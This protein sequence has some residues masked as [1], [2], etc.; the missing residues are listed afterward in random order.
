MLTYGQ[1]V[2]Q[3]TASGGP[4]ALEN[5]TTPHG[6]CRA[7][8]SRPQSIQQAIAASGN[9]Y[10]DK[11]FLVQGESRTSCR[12]LAAQTFG[13]SNLLIDRYGMQ[14]GDRLG[15][16]APNGS[17]WLTAFLGA[18]AAGGVVVLLKQQWQT[19]ELDFAMRH[20]L[21]RFLVVDESLWPKVAPALPNLPNIEKV[22]FIGD[23][24]PPAGTVPFRELNSSPTLTPPR[25]TVH[26]DDP[27][28]IIYTSGTTGQPKGVVSTHLGSITQAQGI[29]LD[30][31]ARRLSS[32]D[33]VAEAQAT[34]S[35]C[36]L[37]YPLANVNFHVVVVHSL[38]AGGKVV[39]T[40]GRRFTPAEMLNLMVRERVTDWLAVPER[41]HQVAMA[42]DEA[43][44]SALATLQTVTLSGYVVHPTIADIIREKFPPGVQIDVGYGL[45]EATGTVAIAHSRDD[46]IQLGSGYV[47]PVLPCIDVKIVD[48]AG[49]EVPQ[50]E[51]GEIY[52]HGA[53]L[54]ERYW[55]D[56]DLTAAAFEDGW[57]RTGDIGKVDPDGALYIVGR[58]GD[59]INRGGAKVDPVEVERHLGGH[60]A[61]AEVAVAGVKD[62]LVGQRV[63]AFV[64]LKPGASLSLEELVRFMTGKVAHF[65]I[66]ERLIILDSLPR[67]AS[68]KVLRGD[69]TQKPI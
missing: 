7:F 17:R 28:T 43:T 25:V 10:G 55:G 44:R 27:F 47:G 5:I 52:L 49:L 37:H 33:S 53:T 46:S 34:D 30:R 38:L 19:P 4:F 69:L 56:A 66:P 35:V 51:A 58:K 41:A 8:A 65:K 45:T 67:N 11:N 13:I 48:D 24:E 50:G 64:V 61:I 3:L 12:Q 42:I 1:A 29:I 36:L 68:G 63:A 62:E 21:C 14:K 16:L 9:L 31:L 6:T 40:T 15:I 32:P 23:S 20:S 59:Q 57:F 54:A 18:A 26:G 39:F 22:F 2:R 60:P